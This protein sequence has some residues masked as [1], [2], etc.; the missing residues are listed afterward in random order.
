M[1]ILYFLLAIVAG[2]GL[3]SASAMTAEPASAQSSEDAVN[4]LFRKMDALH[5]AGR[6]ADAIPLAE[7]CVALARETYG[8]ARLEYATALTWLGFLNKEQG[9][10]VEAE[11]HY[12][13]ALAITESALG[14]DHPNVA[15]SLSYLVTLYESQGRYAD[16]EP[17]AKRA[18][19]INEKAR[20]PD[21]LDVSLGLNN[22]AALYREQGRY[23]ESEL[24]YL[25]SLA[26]AEK[27]L[28]PDDAQVATR[29]NNLAALYYAQL[30]Y[31]DAEPLYQRSLAIRENA[32]GADHPAVA[33]SLSNLAALYYSQSRYAEAEPLVKRSLAI[34]EKAQGPD[35]PEVA[36]KL[37]NLAEI[38]RAQ[39]AFA[40]AEPPSKRALAIR[41]KALGPDHPDTGL[42]LHNLAGLYFAQRDWKTAASY[43]SR[44]TDVLIRRSLRG[45]E[46]VG[47]V[48]TG[49]ARSDVE[50][51]NFRF[52]ALVKAT[53][54]V[55][56]TDAAGR[57]QLARDMFKTAQWAHGSEAAASLAQMAAR[58]AKGD[59]A[60]ARLVRE[61]QDLASEWQTRDKALIAARSGLPG[62]RNAPGEAAHAARLTAIDAR[63]ADI[64]RTL[65]KDFPEYASLA[66][67]APLAITEVQDLLGSDEAL[68]LF[69]DTPESTPAPEESFI[70]VVT[71]TEAR[72]VRSELGT[73]ALAER[74]V[75]LRCGLDRAAWDGDG[76]S[77]CSTLL[78]PGYKAEDAEA[79]EPLPFD[80]ARAHEL[81][82]ALFGQVQDL[83]EGKH[84]LVVPSG[85]LTAIPFQA[86]VTEP[87][88]A[89]RAD[90]TAYAKAAWLAKR[91]AVTVLPSVASLKALRR[92]AKASKAT[93]PFI[94][95]GNPLLLGPDG[96]D[97]RAWDHQRCKTPSAPMLVASRSVRSA[98]PRFF[99]GGLANV[100]EVRA[101]YPLP[102][103]ADELC[104]VAH[105][106]GAGDSAVYLGARASET[107]I[108][109]LSASGSLAQARVVHFATHGLLAGETEMLTAT[110][111]E[112]ALLLTPPANGQRGGRRPAHRVRDRP[113]ETGCRLGDPLGLQYG[114]RREQQTRRG[115]SFRAG[116]GFLLCGRAHAAGIALGGQLRGDR[117]TDHQ[118]LR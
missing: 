98:I 118:G 84:L 75:A 82:R 47:A 61:R 106:R 73:K 72:W 18:L 116:S 92:L 38:Y 93:Q 45:T 108:K 85:A 20:G 86:L 71:K 88:P 74:V 14:P 28:G 99:R 3:L 41:E 97:R 104:A 68:L 9:R 53:H 110:R 7:K 117:E 10:Y 81:Y 49:K 91:H 35:H 36:V 109:R 67:P 17:L 100:E 33:Q 114:S 56:E 55:A 15:Q 6:D 70:W 50:R 107:T 16:A 43:W 76:A 80:L 65:A 37:N 32:L 58:Q 24:L 39:G 48:L 115:G 23:A 62:Q 2:A 90:A 1:P 63:I 29:L 59:G 95:F 22:L 54:R 112:P 96:R 79:G 13:R 12:R 60:L 94:G 103:T 52:R 102:E 31:T 8:E 34:S 11:P 111:A 87:P 25:R 21:H 57:P 4:E 78:G 89:G 46:T 77:R 27:A 30:R 51:E 105:A 42:S 113:A 64:D 19:A 83:L 66:N 26:I 101:Q 44:S 5:R 69:L 40:E